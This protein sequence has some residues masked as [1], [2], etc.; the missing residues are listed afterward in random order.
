MPYFNEAIVLARRPSGEVQEA[1]FRLERTPV[2]VLS[3]GEVLIKVLWL[4]LDPYMRPMMNDSK[5]YAVPLQLGEVMRG[6]SV[7]QV[8]ESES[9]RFSVGDIVTAHTGWQAFHIAAPS[10]EVV[11]RIDPAGLP[12]SVFLG[13]AG[14]PGRTAYFG[15]NY[16]GKPQ[17]GETVVVA[18]ASGA[19]GSVV[20]QLAKQVGCRVIGI[21]GGA[22]KCAYV[23][24]SLGFDACLDHKGGSLSTQLATA[25]PEG[26][27]IY[28]ENVGGAVTRAVA[29]LLNVG[30]RAPICG[31][32]ASYNAE[33]PTKTE[34]PFDVFGALVHPPEH[35][36]F[37]VTEW[38][39]EHA[40]ATDALCSL[41]QAGRL[42]YHETVAEGL[43][44]AV[45]G[46]RGMLRGEN[47]GKQLVRLAD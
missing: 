19:V 31:Y 41:I 34:T 5:S 17:R 42:K 35:R 22:A 25:C 28:F 29:P 43:Q 9:D 7:G 38:D 36:F 11:R 44:N 23:T 46:F 20:G 18:A 13:A 14:M 21:A 1:D 3:P 4:S 45:A 27:D 30:A 24:D 37:L 33:D 39:A 26:I 12:L 47:L 32:V 6:E 8:I 2:R 15:L 10:D 40:A 16:L